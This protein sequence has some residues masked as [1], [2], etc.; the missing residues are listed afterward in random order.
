MLWNYKENKY[1][2]YIKGLGIEPPSPYPIEMAIV[3][4]KMK[5]NSF[6]IWL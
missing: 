6:L 4:R 2:I 5:P 1:Y 3:E